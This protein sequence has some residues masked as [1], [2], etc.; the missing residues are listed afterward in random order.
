MVDESTRIAAPGDR[1]GWVTR[2]L[3]DVPGVTVTVGDDP[4]AT[5]RY[6]VIPALD[7]A[8]FLL[9]LVSRRVTA[10]SLLA[11]NALRPPKVRAGRAA[12]GLLARAGLLGL[13]KAPVLSVHGTDLLSAF[14]AEQLGLPRLH[15]AIGIRPPDPHHKPTLQLFDD[16][17]RPRGY[18]KVGWNDGTRAMVRAEAATLAELP[19]GG[20]FPAAPRLLL[21]T[22]W[23][24]REIAVIEPMP[25]TVRRVHRPD[26]PRL[27]AMLAVARRGGLPAPPAPVSGLIETWRRRAEGAD[28]RIHGFIDALDSDLTL[29]FGDWHGD[30]VPWNMA[31][32]RRG[33]LVWDWENRSAGVPVGFDLAHQAFQTALSTHGRPAAE[34]AA[35]VDAALAQ[36]GPALGLD[37]AR[38]RFVADAYLVELW[39]RTFEL[40]ADGAGWNPKLHPALLDTLSRRALTH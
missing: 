9:P 40:S 18:A 4:S 29:E 22:R 20:G 13:V 32:H 30:W 39:L 36:H 21:H 38:Q 8:R 2:A 23:H 17:G 25:R 31:R 37:E 6:A 33:L 15:A 3:F 27:D 19:T 28:P 24:G 26:Q 34:C 16:S 35:A 10:A 1:L 12:V 7:T 5:A 14:L 11:Y